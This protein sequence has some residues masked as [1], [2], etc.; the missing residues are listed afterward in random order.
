M[1]KKA[2]NELI[3][4]VRYYD[5]NLKLNF[6]NLAEEKSKP[7]SF[8]FEKVSQYSDCHFPLKIPIPDKNIQDKNGKFS[9]KFA[10]MTLICCEQISEIFTILEVL[11]PYTFK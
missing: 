10:T 11:V 6:F 2:Q 9:H 3:F 4:K 1:L 7:L 5:W 8:Y